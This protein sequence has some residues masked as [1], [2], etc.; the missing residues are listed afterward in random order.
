[1]K[2]V[3]SFSVC[4]AV[5]SFWEVFVDWDVSRENDDKTY[6]ESSADEADL[7]SDQT[8]I[9]LIWAQPAVSWSSLSLTKPDTAGPR[10]G[11]EPGPG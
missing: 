4:E 9:I 11:S 5:S 8:L 10:S 7:G 6:L 1:M 2:K 3:L